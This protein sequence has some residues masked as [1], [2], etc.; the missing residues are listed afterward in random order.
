LR[1]GAGKLGRPPSLQEWKALPESERKHIVPTWNAY[2]GEGEPLLSQ[3]VEEFRQ[4]Y[5]NVRGLS[6][7]GL[8]NYHGSLVIAV[9]TNLIFDK[10][11]V[12]DRYLGLGVHRSSTGTPE[13]FNVFGSYHWAP[14]NYEHLVDTHTDVIRRE[15]GQPEIS[16]EEM[17]YA[18]IGMK[19]EDWIN[20]CRSWGP[21]YTNK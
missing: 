20:R 9:R 17:L 16:R 12:P 10:R 8:A 1:K 5:G 2:S 19:F 21:G 14:E 13:S 11:L 18:L 15:L 6:I 4:E 7:T 3:I